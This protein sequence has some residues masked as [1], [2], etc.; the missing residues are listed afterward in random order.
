MK[1]APLLG[2]IYVDQYKKN[3]EQCIKAMQM[4]LDK[5][6]GLMIF[7]MVHIVERDWWDAIKNLQKN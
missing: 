1:A 3:K 7:D 6:N 5:T 2:S 4:C